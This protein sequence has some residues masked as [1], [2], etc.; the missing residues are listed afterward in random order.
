M[1]TGVIH[2]TYHEKSKDKNLVK[3]LALMGFTQNQ[4]NRGWSWNTHPPLKYHPDPVFPEVVVVSA[5]N[6][7]C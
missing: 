6:L 4:A 7:S 3:K 5:G 1:V 2:A